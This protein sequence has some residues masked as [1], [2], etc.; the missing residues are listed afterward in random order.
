MSSQSDTHKQVSSQPDQLQLGGQRPRPVNVAGMHKGPPN[1]PNQGLGSMLKVMEA[2]Q[3]VPKMEAYC[4][5][6]NCK[7][8]GA[9]AR[10]NIWGRV[11]LG[12]GGGSGPHVGL[13]AF[14][15]S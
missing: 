12:P 13:D 8:E 1:W 7:A 10:T 3:V 9:G 4:N 2:L 14:R 11:W 15:V 6:A 5:A